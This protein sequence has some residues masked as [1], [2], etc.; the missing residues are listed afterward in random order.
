MGLWC[1]SEEPTFEKI[2]LGGG[3]QSDNWSSIFRKKLTKVAFYDR[4]FA[5]AGEIF[6]DQGCQMVYFQTKNTNLGKFL[7]ALDVRIFYG[8]L[9]KCM[10][11]WYSFSGFGVAYQ[12]KSGNPVRDQHNSKLCTKARKK[13]C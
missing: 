5:Y 2:L 3:A 9:E 13:C 8:H 12:E 10:T 4:L 11:L 6:Y 7:R 1:D